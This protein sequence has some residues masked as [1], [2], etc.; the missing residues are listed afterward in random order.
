V[1]ELKGTSLIINGPAD[2][3]HLLL[4]IPPSESL[5]SLLR[6]LKTNSSRWVH[7]QVPERKRF[8]WQTG[9]GAFS[10]SSS[11]VEAVRNYIA[12]QEAHH[13]KVSFEEE[14][15]ALL[16]KHGVHYDIRDLQG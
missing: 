4:A 16:K 7:E 3:V 13:R 1:R 6:V 11:R 2:H 9:Y 14:I 8:G 15:V 12:A 10:V 5:A